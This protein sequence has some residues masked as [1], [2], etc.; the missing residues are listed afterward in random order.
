MRPIAIVCTLRRLAAKVAGNCVMLSLGALLAPHQ[1]G[2]G[3]PLGAEAAAHAT[4]IYLQ[5]LWPDC[6]MLKLDFKNAFTCLRRDK[7]L[8][9]VKEMAPE[10]LPLVHSAYC[11]P[12]SLLIGNETIQSAEGVQQGDHMPTV[13][14]ATLSPSPRCFT[15]CAPHRVSSLPD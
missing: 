10:L 12:S 14:V 1:L 6:L 9:A 8:I 15:P 7:M 13:F 3:T 2:Y 11:T 5:N 4:R